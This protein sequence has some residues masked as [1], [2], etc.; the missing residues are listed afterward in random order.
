MAKKAK[1]KMDEMNND[2]MIIIKEM[3]STQKDKTPGFSDNGMKNR[4]GRGVHEFRIN[5]IPYWVMLAG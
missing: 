1:Q 2:H 3:I 5:G 4:K